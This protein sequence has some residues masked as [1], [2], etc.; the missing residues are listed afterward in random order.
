[1][2]GLSS[3]RPTSGAPLLER[4]STSQMLA[5][6]LVTMLSSLGSSPPQ[7]PASSAQHLLLVDVAVQDPS[8]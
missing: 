1:M 2:N 8:G 5:F 3:A 6:T 7:H 4:G